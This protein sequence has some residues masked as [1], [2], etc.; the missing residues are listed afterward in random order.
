MYLDIRPF[1]FHHPIGIDE[2]TQTVQMGE[3]QIGYNVTLTKNYLNCKS[4]DEVRMILIQDLKILR[5]QL[6][7]ELNTRYSFNEVDNGISS[8]HK[9]R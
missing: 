5:K 1:Y 8:I 4:E 9:T 2:E 7:N 6:E 3:Q